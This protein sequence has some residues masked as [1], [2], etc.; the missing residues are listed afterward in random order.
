MTIL[1]C[2]ASALAFAGATLSRA[3]DVEITKP[4]DYWHDLRAGLH[5][6]CGIPFCP[7]GQGDKHL[8]LTDDQ[9]HAID[10]IETQREV[11]L[12]G[13]TGTG[14][15]YILGCAGLVFTAQLADSKALYG[16][17]K[18]DQT[19]G[20]SWLEL[21]RA[22]RKFAEWCKAKGIEPGETP[23]VAE[24]FPMGK[25]L[26]PEW[27]AKV[28]ALSANDEAAAVRGMMHAG[29]G[30]LACLEE[31][32]GIAP[33]VM[34]AIDDG[35][36]QV[37][38][39]LWFSFNPVNDANPAGQRWAQLPEAGRVTFSGL[40]AAEWQARHGVEI[41]GMPT[42]AAILEKWAGR[43]N[44]PRYYVNVLGQFPPK[45]ADRLVIPQDWY[46]LL[47]DAANYPDDPEPTSAQRASASLG[48]DTAGG[49]AEN[50][51]ASLCG[52]RV[53]VE[54][55]NRELHQTPRLVA[56][57]RRIAD[58]YAGKRTPIAIDLVGEGG[59]G[60]H[61]DLKSLGYNA[62][63]MV[64]GGKEFAEQRDST[65]LSSDAITWAW[66]TA[67]DLARQTVD[68]IC[69]GRPERFIRFPVDP[70]SREQWARPFAV[71]GERHYQMASK[72]KDNPALGL[73]KLTVSPD[74]A[75]AQAMAV[76]AGVVGKSGLWYVGGA[77]A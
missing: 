59:K 41:P 75:D 15:S 45:S 67:R 73:S 65:D 68:A 62:L 76:L 25:D 3:S 16:G 51:V 1:L 61:D 70:D 60:V 46:D 29:G 54:W 35:M 63:P 8:L 47:S 50:V 4:V 38:A 27:F 20:L 22:Y 24:W 64:G 21:L 23:G 56:E 5:D 28:H 14:K 34:N 10:A 57:V 43:E 69:Q 6:L 26:R 32:H 11:G 48:V 72:T 36:T 2:L 19:L 66:F 9:Q 55:A 7:C 77:K 18:L 30:V 31:V 12:C 33:L 74:R 44:D 39:H 53:K 58:T 42:R 13:G 71:N 37:N 52:I 17:P 49:R 40:D